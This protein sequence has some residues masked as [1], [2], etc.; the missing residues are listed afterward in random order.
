[1]T[2]YTV[3][4]FDK[5]ST[6]QPLPNETG[7]NPPSSKFPVKKRVN[8]KIYAWVGPITRIGVDAIVNTTS[9]NFSERGGVSGSVFDAA[10][11]EL[12]E[13]CATLEG[14]RT[15][16]AKLTSAYNLPCKAIIH[17]VGPRYN[18]RYQTAAENALH[19][20]YFHALEELVDAGLRS[21]AFCCVNT[22]RKSYPPQ[23]AVH[24]IARTV[25]RFLEKYGNKI[26]AVC[27]VFQN[28]AE[29]QPYDDVLPLYFPRSKPEQ[30]RAVPLLPADTGNDF[31]ETVVA[32]RQVRVGASY[33]QTAGSAARD[34]ALTGYEQQDWLEPGQDPTAEP[35]PETETDVQYGMLLE[36]ARNR[37]FTS[38][39]RAKILFR[40]GTDKSGLPIFAFCCKNL[41]LAEVDLDELVLYMVRRMDAD[42]GDHYTLI[43]VHTEATDANVPSLSWV[44]QVYDTLPR[45]YKKNLQHL[46]VL[47][48]TF[49]LKCMLWFLQTFISGKFWRKMI[50]YDDLD[51]MAEHVDIAALCRQLPEW[52]DQYNSSSL[53]RAPRVVSQQSTA[54]GGSRAAHGTDGL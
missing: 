29:R 40:A 10:G 5:W 7:Q 45:K 9:E 15:G 53:G 48:P 2:V 23:D 42:V 3:D 31:G 17:T 52:V 18:V 6:L 50:R 25:R 14:C 44:R 41:A 47:H 30:F 49:M 27:F 28:A 34:N 12:A 51:L 39:A 36:R 32:E 13:E 19:H 38:L 11:A 4:H 35:E 43:Y 26:D 8:D 16:E 33:Q 1:M 24:I 37:D 20:C 21:I 46:H 54:S 22:E